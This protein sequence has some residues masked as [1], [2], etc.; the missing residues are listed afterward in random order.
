VDFREVYSI[1]KRLGEGAFGT[2]FECCKKSD[3]SKTTYAVKMM[4]HQTSWWGRF[5]PSQEAQWQMFAQEFKMLKTMQHPNLIRMVEVFIDDYFVYF[6]MDKYECSLISAV[7]PILKKGHRGLSSAVLGKIVEQMLRSI[8]YM[9]S[10]LI[11]HRDVKADNYLVDGTT[12]KNRDFKV[13]LT[14]L[15]TARHLEDGVFLTHI[16]GTQEYWAPELVSR[17]YAHKVDVWAVGIILWCM[18]TLKFPFSS[19]QE[20]FTKKLTKQERMSDEQYH[21][22]MGLLQKSQMQRLTAKEAI[23]HNWV[24]T[25]AEAHMNSIKDTAKELNQVSDLDVE[26]VIKSQDGR[27]FGKTK[28]VEMK[29]GADDQQE[30]VMQKMRLAEEKFVRG[31]RVAI[32][33]QDK[34]D[35]ADAEA[36]AVASAG[37]GGAV[38]N[39]VSFTNK[40][41]IGETK[42]YEWWSRK[43]CMAKGVPDIDTECM[44]ADS[45]STDSVTSMCAGD[46]VVGEP[47]NV[48]YL[49]AFM[50]DR[51]IDLAQF[52]VGQAK[53]LSALYQELG[54][55]ECCLL[56]RDGRVIRLVDLVVLR[57]VSPSG[58]YLVEAEQTFADGRKRSV[59][60]LPAVMC[61]AKGKGIESAMLEINR[62]LSSELK[63]TSKVIA[64]EAVNSQEAVSV[65]KTVSQSYPGL[66]SIYRRFIFNASVNSDASEALLHA[67]GQPQENNFET[68]LND[69][70][71]IRWEWWDSEK[72]KTAGIPVE[73]DAST[74]SASGEFEGFQRLSGVNWTEDSLAKLLTKHKIDTELFG[75]EGARTMAQ[76]ASEVNSGET[77]LYEKPNS[78]GGLRRYLEILIV[79]VKNTFGAYFIETAHK[80][81]Q[82]LERQRNLFPATKLRPFEDK[83]WAVR[84][85]LCELDIPF[86]NAK[87]CFGPTRTEQTLSPSYPNIVTV[88]LK[89]VVEVQLEDIDIANLENE[90]PVSKK[91]YL[92]HRNSR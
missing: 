54:K 42:T 49:E 35:Q 21:L 10:Q 4:E 55:H 61:R 14:D 70:T 74:S 45:Q 1:G 87:T 89:Q 80:F 71:S 33:I 47:A 36:R 75:V 91:W 62:I 85:L 22:L 16:V 41:R 66:E 82:G 15:S 32:T 92:S 31:E 29:D 79:R 11:V 50:T 20:R 46:V 52:G 3:S 8:V 17:S 56:V 6:V 57:I 30:R 40:Q 73:A 9:H 44:K 59:Q 48:D 24:V 12:F 53:T 43:R 83:I 68:T 19:V 77:R 76:L 64:V 84:R 86:A 51:E 88:Y 58:R 39:T 23:E 63:T 18:L 72:C 38:G 67:L 26:V 65:E 34:L 69:H 27:E 28:Q 60:R 37:D 2:V 81:G 5:S 78:P 25:Q 7:L 90:Q 13:V